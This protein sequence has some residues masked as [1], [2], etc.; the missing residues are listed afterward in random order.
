MRRSRA[1]AARVEKEAARAAWEQKE[2]VEVAMKV[3]ELL[4]ENGHGANDVGA[5]ALLPL[6]GDMQLLVPPA[7]VR[8]RVRATLGL[9]L[10]WG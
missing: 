3:Q 7:Q 5:R 9:G 6:Q 2:V 1:G 10:P 4:F 8:V